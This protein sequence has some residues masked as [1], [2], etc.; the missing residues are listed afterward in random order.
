MRPSG[1]LLITGPLDAALRWADALHERLAVT[2]LATGARPAP[3]CRPSAP[4]PSTP[5][6]SRRSTAGSARSTSRGRR[7]IRST[8]TFARAATRACAP[9][10]SRRSTRATRSTSI[11]A[12]TIAR[13]SPRA[14][15]SAP[16]T[17][18]A[19]TRRAP[20]ASTS[21]STCTHARGSTQHQ[22]PQGYF[23]P[24]ADALAQAKAVA[25]LARLT[26]RIR[27]A[28][29]LPLQGIAVRA[30]PLAHP[31]LHASASTC[32]RRS[33]SGRTAIASR[34]SRICAWAAARARPCARRARSRTRT[35]PV[36]DL[37]ARIKTLLSTYATRGR[38]RRVPAVPRRGWPR[39][40]RAHGAAR[41]AG[42]RR[43]SSRSRCTTSRRSASTSG[44]R[45][46]RG[47]RRR[48]RCSRP[49]TRR[50][51]TATRSR[52]RCGRRHDRQGARL[53]GRALPHRRR[54]RARRAL[55]NGRPRCG[56]RV[57]ATFA[58]TPE[59]RTTA[60]LAIE[61]LAAACADAARR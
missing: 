41:H 12:R 24:G 18:R 28:A 9:A 50:R 47:A 14:A 53:P 57:A 36:P 15:P 38:A 23:R 22:P 21:C 59:K 54:R 39:G 6:S 61:H 42:C 2:V 60:A 45:R 32:A 43:A 52:S 27:E 40:D 7:R 10:R 30:Q 33:R 49:A 16:S 58:A 56:P 1:Q 20:S 25:E 46:S 31:G 35:R 37:A 5:G 26:R 44:S 19:R 34:S 11:A 29:I 3:R 8:S 13:A 17:S 51:S 48:S 55:R 4:I